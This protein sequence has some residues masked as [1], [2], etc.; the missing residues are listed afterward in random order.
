MLRREKKTPSLLFSCE[1]WEFR[2]A[3]IESAFGE[4]LLWFPKNLALSSLNV[5]LDIVISSLSLRKLKFLT[6]RK[7]ANSSSN[8]PHNQWPK[9]TL[10]LCLRLLWFQQNHGWWSVLNFSKYSLR[11][12]S[13][14]FQIVLYQTKESI[15]SKDYQQIDP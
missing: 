11:I 10:T 9:I 5:Y 6:S 13:S 8:L 3:F 15:Q 7:E 12:V 1:F 4:F 2:R 14:F